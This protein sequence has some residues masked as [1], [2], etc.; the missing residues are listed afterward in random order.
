MI[1]NPIYPECKIIQY[2]DNPIESHFCSVTSVA[3]FQTSV[4]VV[5]ILCLIKRE[6]FL[7]GDRFCW[8]ALPCRKRQKDP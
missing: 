7:M 1:L 5:V 8:L 4:V 3:Q 2:P 6:V